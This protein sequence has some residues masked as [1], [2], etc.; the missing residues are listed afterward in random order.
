MSPPHETER[1]KI[2]PF[3]AAAIRRLPAPAFL[4]QSSPREPDLTRRAMGLGWFLFLA[5]VLVAIAGVALL[6]TAWS[7]SRVRRRGEHVP[8]ALA[9]PEPPRPA[10]PVRAVSGVNVLIAGLD[11]ER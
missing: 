1:G 6:G 5:I 7:G 8:G 9:A 2:V 4:T 10:A 3:P 11:G